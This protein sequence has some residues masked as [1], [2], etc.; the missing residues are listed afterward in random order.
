[1]FQPKVVSSTENGEDVRKS[2][3]H[4]KIYKLDNLKSQHPGMDREGFILH[5]ILN[6]Q[7][8]DVGELYDLGSQDV[9][10]AAESGLGKSLCA[11]STTQENM[12]QWATTDFA[13]YL[14]DTRRN[15]GIFRQTFRNGSMSK[16]TSTQSYRPQQYFQSF[17]K[18]KIPF[19]MKR[20][21]SHFWL[22]SFN[23]LSRSG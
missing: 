13:R 23:G 14:K 21:C 20:T 4:F 6:G 19:G 17:R 2:K 12:K 9:L 16:I 8:K 3:T 7:P 11:A 18:H 5:A 15:L 10:N 1:M 22:T